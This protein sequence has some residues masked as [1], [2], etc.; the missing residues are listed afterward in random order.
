MVGIE[1]PGMEKK[2]KSYSLEFKEQVLADVESGDESLRGAA[3]K[4]GV[5]PLTIMRWRAKRELGSLKGKKTAREQSLEKEVR[6]L[7]EKVGELTLAVDA[8][9]KL[10]AY[11][12]RQK[13]ADTSVITGLNLE[14]LRGDA[15]P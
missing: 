9:K 10:K 6:Q 2:S 1:E 4:Y 8:L 11:G 14:E 3:R 15:K 12:R 13:S 5:A 7:R